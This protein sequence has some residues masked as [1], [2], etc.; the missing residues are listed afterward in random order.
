VTPNLF[1]GTP[2]FEHEGV[3]MRGVAKAAG[4]EL[5]GATAYELAP[6]ARWAD[7]HYHHANEELLLVL[8][9][10]PTLHTLEGSRELEPGDV[11]AF[12]RGRRGAHR[13]SNES[14]A[15]TRF[16]LVSTMTMPEVVEYPE[17]E[18][19]FVMS[20][21]PWTDA[22]YDE[23]RGRVIRGFAMQDGLPIP[24]DAKD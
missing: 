3:T 4:A 9:G 24:P 12:R 15:P 8:E 10:T 18:R 16:V 22:P 7:L 17:S 21:P 23:T 19:V 20:E 1:R 5:L 13:L 11:V 2:D 6:G 14:S